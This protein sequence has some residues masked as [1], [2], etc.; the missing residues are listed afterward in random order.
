MILRSIARAFGFKA[1]ATSTITTSMELAEFIRS[2]GLTDAGMSVSPE[3]AM[4]CGTVFACVRVLSESI[5]QLPFP[6]YRRQDDD[7]RKRDRDHALDW[8]LNFQPN[9]WQTAFEFREM[10]MGHLCLRGNAYAFINRINGEVRSLVPLH[11]D[12]I[13]PSQNP[14]WSMKYKYTP[15]GGTQRDLTSKEIFHLRGISSDGIVGVSPITAYREA[16]GLALATLRHQ[17]KSFG[18]GVKFNGVLSAPNKLDPEARKNI[19]ESFQDMHSNENAFRTPLLEQGLQWTSVGMTGQDAQT[20]ETR[21]LTR[22]DIASVFRVPPHKIGDLERATFS[23]IEHQ[24]IEF[25]T[26]CLTP[27]CKRWEQR[28]QL[29]LLNPKDQR[30]HYIEHNLDGLIRGDIK[31]RYSAYGQAIKDGWMNRNEVRVRENLNRVDGLDEFLEPLNMANPK[32]RGSDDDD[33]EK[34]TKP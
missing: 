28:G 29:D 24:A 25:V 8:V 11:P 3:T 16:V 10:L 22:T 4:R 7:G 5:A 23:N 1:A 18:A 19:K 14:D 31:T 34:P 17:A 15:D 6:V 20:I 13:V 2:S 12:R 26:D 27:Y 32:D 9:Q 30:T 33:D 21:K